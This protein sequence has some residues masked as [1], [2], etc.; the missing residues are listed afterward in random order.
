M[1]LR[2]NDPVAETRVCSVSGENFPVYA[3]DLAFYERVTPIWDSKR[4]DLPAPVLSPD[5]RER[6]RI[7]WRNERKLSRRTCDLTGKSIVSMYSPDKSLKVYAV[8]AWQSDAWDPLSFGRDFDFSRP[9]F[10]QFVELWRDVPHMALAN[11][12]PEY[13][14]N[15]EYNNYLDGAKN[16]YLNIMGTDIQDS[17]YTT[18]SAK[19]RS[20]LDVWWSYGL[21]RCYECLN[22]FSLYE[23]L[24]CDDCASSRYL[25]FCDGCTDCTHCFMCVGLAHREYCVFN[26]QLSKEE[27]FKRLLSVP[28]SSASALRARFDSFV[29]KQKRQALHA[30]DDEDCLGDYV[31]RS[32]DARDCFV[33]ADSHNMAYVRAAARTADVWDGSVVYDGAGTVL[34]SVD[35]IDSSKVFFSINVTAGSDVW[36]CAEIVA[37][38]S[39]F[40]CVGLRN[41]TSC[42]LNKSYSKMEYETLC[43][44]IAGHMRDTGEW[45][46]FFPAKLAPFGYDESSAMEYFPL[47]HVEALDRGLPWSGYEAPAPAVKTVL[48]GGRIPVDARTVGD[49]ILDMAIRCEVSG[50][51]FR[52]VAAELAYYRRFALPIP[53]RHPDVRHHDR[54][55][56]CN[57][58][59]LW[60]RP[61]SGCGV[62]TAT[63]YAP[64]RPEAILCRA[65]YRKEIFG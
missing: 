30:W 10:E 34:Q 60:D 59:T 38:Q 52:L 45:G 19:L 39:L 9:F 18:D 3:S 23:C 6:Q 63:S 24:Y 41:Q 49:D 11:P 40:G 33:V 22:G 14:E 32:K 37:G 48:E 64:D 17:C 21:E 44:R 16:A 55:L 20:S 5:E 62:E 13:L 4:F 26:E 2:P 58:R 1:S 15:S 12:R 47:S 56:R 36:Y 8:D 43:A 25:F 7:G 53:R 27:Y 51:L 28:F 29:A 35:V 61:C 46:E 65:C 54:M 57:P 31:Y 42:V 50:R